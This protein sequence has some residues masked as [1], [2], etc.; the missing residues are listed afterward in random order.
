MSS[1]TSQT[2]PEFP[3][4]DNRTTRYRPIHSDDGAAAF[5]S[6]RSTGFPAGEPVEAHSDRTS[7]LSTA[8][9]ARWGCGR[10]SV[11]YGLLDP[12]H[13]EWLV[14]LMDRFPPRWRFHRELLNQLP[15][16]KR[17]GNYG[18]PTDTSGPPDRSP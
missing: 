18:R 13:N 6:G 15:V 12:T 5:V 8:P 4:P 16:Y 7:A 1:F 14:A 9:E 17:T 10:T 3:L 11:Q 2:R